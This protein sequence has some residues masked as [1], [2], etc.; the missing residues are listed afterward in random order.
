MLLLIMFYWLYNNLFLCFTVPS[1]VCLPENQ[2]LCAL[3]IK[4]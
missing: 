1:F 3:K 2:Y 4:K